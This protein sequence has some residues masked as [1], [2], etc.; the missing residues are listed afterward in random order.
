MHLV[1]SGKNLNLTESLKSYVEEKLG[2]IKRFFDSITE[3]DVTLGIEKT[4]DPD[5]SKFAEVV[6]FSNGITLYAKETSS[7]MYAA[8]DLVS[9]K[10]ERQVKKHKEKLKEKSRKERANKK[11]YQATHSLVAFDEEEDTPV[12]IRSSKFAIKPMYVEE[13]AEQLK[14]LDQEFFVFTNAETEE[15]NV[16]YKRKDGN[17]GLIEPGV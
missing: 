13:A 4:L 10:L 6:L 8:I 14:S 11:Y 17:F 16:I 15:V 2:R 7:D 1:I 9:D 5:K 3:L 12:I